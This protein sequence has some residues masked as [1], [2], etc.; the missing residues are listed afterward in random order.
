MYL[1]AARTYF[2][3]IYS[4]CCRV[5]EMTRIFRRSTPSLCKNNSDDDDNDEEIERVGVDKE[6]WRI[7][8]ARCR[9]RASIC[10]IS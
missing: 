10:V 8:S 2:K 9:S 1:T 3:I 6:G 7:R 5:D 4:R